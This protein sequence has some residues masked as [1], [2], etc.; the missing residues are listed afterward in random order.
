MYSF[1]IILVYNDKILEMSE[2]NAQHDHLFYK[3]V[4]GLRFQHAT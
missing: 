3:H 2:K 1:N 4:S